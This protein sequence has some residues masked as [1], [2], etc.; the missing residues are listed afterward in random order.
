MENFMG[1]TMLGAMYYG[2]EDLRVERIPVPACPPDGIL[3][4]IGAATTCGTDIKIYKRGY[5]ELPT[6]PMPFGHEC[7]GVVAEVGPQAGGV[8][9]GERIVAGLA[10]NC[11]KCYW[12]KRNQPVFC[13]DRTYCIPGGK[14]AGGAYAEYLAVPGAIVKNNLHRI[15]D[16]MPFAQASLVEPLA[17]ALYGVEDLPEL[18][19]GDH[20]VINGAGPIGLFFLRL[21]KLRG[22]YAVVCGSH[23]HRLDKAQ[24]LGA[25]AIINI[26]EVP[27]QIEA[28]YATLGT[29]G[30]DVV[31][32]S[33]GI[34]AVWEL[35]VNMARRGGTVLLFGGCKGGTTVT[36][37]TRK[38]HYDCLTIKSP[39]VYIQDPDLLSRSLRLLASGDVPGSAFL[40]DRFPLAD[41][42]T[43]VRKHMAREGIKYE[44]VPP[45]FW[46]GDLE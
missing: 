38:V 36:L 3:L 19:A 24:E 23:A 10:A 20:V 41:A 4:Q 44:I 43:A 32:E 30:P 27:D 5:P 31:I 16:G 1:V 46:D 28:V 37:D 45:E 12:C 22:A 29:P 7:A 35:S 8:E 18:R 2:P 11:G 14:M 42:V 25:D 34:P 21:V 9:V 6:L 15:P 13:I 40:S 39:S 26:H 17:C 33:T